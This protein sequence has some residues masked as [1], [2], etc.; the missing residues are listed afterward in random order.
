M[1]QALLSL[2]IAAALGAGPAI[3]QNKGPSSGAP[4]A[5]ASS[6]S[7]PK[8]DAKLDRGDRNFIAK[9]AAS[10][11]AEVEAGKLAAGKAQNPDIKQ[12][13]QQ[14][15]DDHTKAN[16]ELKSLASQKGLQL[17]SAIDRKHVAEMKKLEKASGTDFDRDYIRNL[18]TRDHAEAVKLFQKAS[19]DAKDPEVKA[20]A[21]KYLPIIARHEE[22][23]K[24]L[25][26]S[27][28]GAKK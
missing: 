16:E 23:A 8:G 17:P 6:S 4:A 7:A 15:V 11:M 12:F 25:A 28:K 27:S 22:T 10:G 9:A 3:A 24:S 5:P 19:K 18:G 21:A 20:F 2:A 26:G 1:K 13:G 14:M